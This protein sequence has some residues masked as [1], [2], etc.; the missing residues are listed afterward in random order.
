MGTSA[1][2]QARDAESSRPSGPSLSRGRP[3]GAVIAGLIVLSFSVASLPHLSPLVADTLE[4]GDGKL[5]SGEIVKET[6]REI[7]IDIGYTIVSVPREMVKARIA[8]PVAPGPEGSAGGDASSADAAAAGDGEIFRVGRLQAV[9]LKDAMKRLGEGVVRVRCSGKMGSGFVI[10][11]RGYVVT[12]FH[13]IENERN[14]EVILFLEGENG[15]EKKRI[16]DVE[17]IALNEF[18]DL[19]LLRIPEAAE[20]PLRPLTLAEPGSLKAGESVFAIG[21]PYGFERTVSEGII[22]DPYR[23]FGGNCYIQTTAPINPGNSGGALFNSRGEVIGVTNM[24]IMLSEG[25]NFAIPINQLTFFLERRSSFLFD[26][27]RPNTGVHY[28]DPPRK[29]REME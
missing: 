20:V 17:I 16:K 1:R 5:L 28:L 8:D 12:N 24:K 4:L 7:F 19:A 26:E 10:D 27:S 14:I 25:L 9:E 18:L 29:I 21:A 3:R 22:S 15:L 13:V 23:S 6:E 11:R 2:T